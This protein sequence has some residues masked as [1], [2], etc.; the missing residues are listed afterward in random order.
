VADEKDAMQLNGKS[1]C[2]L[3]YGCWI[4]LKKSSEQQGTID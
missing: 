3:N 2:R 1:V 4:L